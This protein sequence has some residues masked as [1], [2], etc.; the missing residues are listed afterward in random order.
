MASAVAK[1]EPAEPKKAMGR[2][3]ALLKPDLEQTLLDYIRI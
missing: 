3:T 1:K 2:K